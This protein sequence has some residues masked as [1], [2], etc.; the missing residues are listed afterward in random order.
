MYALILDYIFGLILVASFMKVPSVMRILEA[1]Q[2]TR[3]LERYTKV[4][5]TGFLAW[6][7][8]LLT[9][10]IFVFV[11]NFVPA[12][13]KT[14]HIAL[15]LNNINQVLNTLQF[16]SAFQLIRAVEF[17]M[18]LA[19]GRKRINSY[20]VYDES[21]S[22]PASDAAPS[23]PSQIALF[24]IENPSLLNEMPGNKMEEEAGARV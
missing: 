5:R 2:G 10:I 13:Y 19:S 7:A 23:T 15:I 22:D 11:E 12:V 16:Y 3:H 14:I 1:M 4:A 18:M 21:R 8:L 6:T 9:L 17:L 20:A 24:R